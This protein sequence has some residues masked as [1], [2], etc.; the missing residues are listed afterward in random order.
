MRVGQ[1]PAKTINSVHQ[2][3]RITLSVITYAPFLSG[4]YA[5]GLEVLKVCLTSI[6]ENT[7][8]EADL[9]IFDNASCVEIRD[10]LL[11]EH[12]RGNIQY[13]VLSEKN[14]GKGGAWNFIFNAAP[15]EIIAYA[16]GDVFFERGWLARSLEI[17]DCYPKVGMVTARPLRTPKTHWTRTLEW[18]GA[19]PGVRMAQGKFIPWDAYIEHHRSLGT[20]EDQAREWFETGE[21]YRLTYRGI[22]AQIGAAHFQFTAYKSVLRQ[23][24]P[25]SMDRPMGQVRSLDEA[26]NLAGFLRL[27]TSQPLVRHLGNRL[28]IPNFDGSNRDSRSSTGRILDVPLIRRLLLSIYHSIFELYYR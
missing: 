16:D 1:N 14:I 11:D 6:R 15:G 20:S 7:E 23:F 24:L 28:E 18:A 2:P 22:T 27:S 5:Q 21:D 19:T 4:Y 25:F 8:L 9:L 26:I 10:F 17:L 13:L 3:E 12:R